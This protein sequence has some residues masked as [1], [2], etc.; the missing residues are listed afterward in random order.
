MTACYTADRTRIIKALTNR[1][2]R[3]KAA[4]L[5]NLDKDFRLQWT[6]MT[7]ALAVNILLGNVLELSAAQ[8]TGHC[9]H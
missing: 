2:A 7:A 1:W 5:F 8:A 6:L 9:H 4:P 3:E